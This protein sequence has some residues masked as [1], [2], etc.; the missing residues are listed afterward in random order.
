M[1][2]SIEN[3]QLPIGAHDTDIS[4]DSENRIH[5]PIVVIDLDEPTIFAYTKRCLHRPVLAIVLVGWVE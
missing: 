2:I 5:L 3:L 1:S 4:I